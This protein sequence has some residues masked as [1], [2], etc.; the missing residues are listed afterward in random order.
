MPRTEFQPGYTRLAADWLNKIDRILH[1]GVD[2]RTTPE[3]VRQYIGAAVEQTAEDHYANVADPHN[4]QNF[5][6]DGAVVLVTDSLPWFPFPDIYYLLARGYQ[7]VPERGFGGALP[8]PYVLDLFTAADGTLLSAH[9]PELLRFTGYES[10]TQTGVASDGIIKDNTVEGTVTPCQQLLDCGTTEV[11]VSA[12][13]AASNKVANGIVLCASGTS[14]GPIT[15]GL[16]CKLAGGGSFI[17][18][19][20]FDLAAGTITQL[21]EVVA[22]GMAAQEASYRITCRLENSV[23]YGKVEDSS[24]RVVVETS[25]DVSATGPYTGTKHGLWLS[26]LAGESSMDNFGIWRQRGGGLWVFS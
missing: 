18:F 24:G 20:F 2:F 17:S 21:H 9:T 22:G 11:E 26:S 1:D 23:L 19:R 8:D 13:Y 10:F 7:Y 5:L 15:K 25:F 12:V 4:D 3:G 6:L 14:P 16:L